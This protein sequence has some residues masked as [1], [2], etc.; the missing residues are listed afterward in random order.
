MA[1]TF[2]LM[3]S[4]EKSFR[5]GNIEQAE[6]YI[7]SAMELSESKPAFVLSRIYIDNKQYEKAIAFLEDFISKHSSSSVAYLYLGIAHLLNYSVETSIQY[8]EKVKTL[9]PENILA[10]NFLMLCRFMLGEK[11]VIKTMQLKFLH[12]NAVFTAVLYL[13][14]YKYVFDEDIAELRLLLEQAEEKLAEEKQLTPLKENVDNDLDVLDDLSEKA[15]DVDENSVEDIELQVTLQ[16]EVQIDEEDKILERKPSFIDSFIAFF[17]FL[18]GRNFLEREKIEKAI[19]CFERASE[20]DSKISRLHFS[21]GEALIFNKQYDLAQR[22]LEKALKDD[23]EAPEIMYYLGRIYQKQGLFDKADNF[24]RKTLEKFNKFPEIYIAYGE[25][26]IVKNDFSLA[27]EH[28][29]KACNGDSFS[30]EEL[31]KQAKEK[32][33]KEIK[34]I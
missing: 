33:N 25:M 9:S 21:Y 34:G 31:I 14:L 3:A 15:V 23:G 10:D 32:V 24:F 13:E 8:F 29:K 2:S 1:G 19:S 20:L 6:I 26:A 28:F 17:Y 4:A 11:E 16:K 22:E 12:A 27:F 7:N 30:L 5:Q 18:R